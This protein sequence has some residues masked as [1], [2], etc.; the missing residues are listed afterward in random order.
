MEG[1]SFLHFHKIIHRDLKPDN[2][3]F[4]EGNL[5]ISDFGLSC[6]LNKKENEMKMTANVGA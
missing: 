2:L 4:L 1:L 6:D 3:L 5:K